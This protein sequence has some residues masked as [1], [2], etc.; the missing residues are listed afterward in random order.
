ME[1]DRVNGQLPPITGQDSAER[2]ASPGPLPHVEGYHIVEPIGQGGMGTVWSAVQL[3]TRREVALKLL[4]KGAFSSEKSQARFEREVELTARLEHPNIARI[5]DSGLHQGVHYYAMELIEGIPLDKYVKEHNLTQRQILELMRT[6]CEA[7]QHAHERGVIHRDLKPS[8]ILVTPDDQPHVLD[9]GLAKGFLEGDS[10]VTVSADGEAAGTPA[11]MSP[12]QAAGKVEKLDTRTDVFSMGVVLFRLLTGESPHDLSGTRY[13]V[14]RRIAKEDAKRPREITK[15][16]D[17]ELEAL[18]LKALAHDPKDRYPSAGALAQDIENYLNGEPLT[19]RPPTTAYF[20]RKRLRKYRVRLAVASSVLAVLIAV[21]VFAYMRVTQSRDKLQKEVDKGIAVRN[22]MRRSFLYS[23]TWSTEGE[24]SVD[25]AADRIV[26]EFA[27]RPEVEAAARMA[28]GNAYLLL[29]RPS[30]AEHQF[31]Q[32]LQMRRRVLEGDHADI[33]ESMEM[34]SIALWSAEGPERAEAIERQILEIRERTLGDRHPDTLASMANLTL[35]FYRR[36]RFNEVAEMAKQC[37]ATQREAMLE[38]SQDTINIMV[39]LV[40][41]QRRQG[42][43]YVKETRD[44]VKIARRVLG[45]G[46]DGTLN[47]MTTLAFALEEMG[48]LGDAEALRKEEIALRKHHQPEDSW[49]T[50]WAMNR[51][52]VL[53]WR[54]GK[55]DEAEDINRQIFEKWRRILGPEH[56][57]TLAAMSNLA[58]ILEESGKLVK[59]EALREEELKIRRSVVERKR[60]GGQTA[61]PRVKQLPV[62]RSPSTLAYD[63]FD[64]GLA[65]DWRIQNPD[66]VHLS[67]TTNPGTLTITTQEGSFSGSSKDYEDL[68]LIDSPAAPNEDFQLTTCISFFPLEADSHRAGLIFHD[69][70]NYLAFSLEWSGYFGGPVFNVWAETEG[71]P[72]QVNFPL[73]YDPKTVWLRVAKKGNRYTFST[74]YDGKAFTQRIYPLNWETGQFHRGT[75][76]GD[77]SVQRIGLFAITGSASGA[78]EID[79][80]FDFFEVRSL[81][82]EAEPAAEMASA[83]ESES[84]GQMPR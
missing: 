13:E 33:V 3:S 22:F 7:V 21:S 63:D 47:W 54:R 70:D 25:W 68:F 81:P 83:P 56:T 77:G 62:P 29:G 23:H 57:E 38:D 80:S 67:L 40:I 10:V 27:G 82:T 12:E 84:D 44:T 64:G 45:E 41:A 1:K 58:L 53:L 79:A 18:L 14:L 49:L 35:A 30:D 52:A 48:N 34:L 71:H 5:Y 15:D 43:P 69:D 72:A 8:N 17:R 51:Y 60:T 50:L 4:G 78:S 24:W 46:H 76:W 19:A 59:A 65:L 16:I 20:L 75:A 55:L 37:L 2:P 28:I 32:A 74:S 61:L 39:A 73:L 66:A 36:G 6:V 42:K 31:S 26:R 9:F 11:Y